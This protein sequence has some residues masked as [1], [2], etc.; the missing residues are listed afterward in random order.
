[1]SLVSV[2]VCFVILELVSVGPPR[3][4]GFHSRESDYNGVERLMRQLG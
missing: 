1:M 3:P 2:L 4:C